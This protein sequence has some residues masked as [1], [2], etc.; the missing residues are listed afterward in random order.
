MGGSHV[1]LCRIT[2][3]AGVDRAGRFI[4]SPTLLQRQGIFTEAI[5]GP[6]PVIYDPATT[7]HDPIP[8]C[9]QSRFLGPGWIR[10]RFRCWSGIRCRPRRPL[11]NFRR[12]DSEIDNQDQWDA[13]IDHKFGL[14][15]RPGIRPPD[16]FPRRLRPGD[17]AAGRERGDVAAPLSPQDTDRMG[18]RLQLPA[19]VLRQCAQRDTHRRYAANG[20]TDRRAALDIGEGASVEHSGIPSNAQ[21][22]NT[23]PNT[24]SRK[25]RSPRER[26]RPTRTAD[27]AESFR[28]CRAGPGAAPSWAAATASPPPVRSRSRSA[29]SAPHPPTRGGPSGF[30]P[31]RFAPS[32]RQPGTPLGA[33]YAR[34]AG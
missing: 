24:R 14:E 28:R 27:R 3:A 16:V 1:L 11:N 32:G 22:P 9:G 34:T 5:A 8:V 21:F 15:S 7:V 2:R 13:R 4:R 20:W 30:R 12:T 19:H 6:V 25:S 33:P 23:L 31:P 29:S 10:W 17:A 18:V 26:A